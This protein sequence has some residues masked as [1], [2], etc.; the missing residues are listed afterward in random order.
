MS[1]DAF[2]RCTCIRD[3]KVK[4][5]HPFPGRLTLDD[6]SGSPSLTGDPTEE[7]WEAHDQWVQDSC[8]HE[9]FLVSEFLGNITR[10]Q[11][12]REFLRGLQGDPGPKFPILLKKVVY[13][14]THTGDWI[15]VKQTPALLREVTT[16]LASSDILTPGEK[17]FF[18]A[19]KRLC[20]ASIETGN[21]INF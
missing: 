18:E 12:V 9:G 17:E 5:P 20:D 3:G 16:V 4:K 21:P 10:A 14:G 15:P 2:V 1:L 11:H 19:M 8:E 6:H 13:D 7:E